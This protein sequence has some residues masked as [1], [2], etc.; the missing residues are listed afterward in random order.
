MPARGF[1]AW[2]DNPASPYGRDEKD[3]LGPM[4]SRPD[5]LVGS[6]GSGSRSRVPCPGC[7]QARAAAVHLFAAP[8]GRHGAF[9][10]QLLGSITRAIRRRGDHANV[11]AAGSCGRPSSPRLA[12]GGELLLA[13]RRSGRHRRAACLRVRDLASS[14]G[15]REAIL[16]EAPPRPRSQRPRLVT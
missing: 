13:G 8:D 12:G 9:R 11:G 2:N 3:P 4:I 14:H 6:L 16:P 7:G 10:S 5:R 1:L 15:R